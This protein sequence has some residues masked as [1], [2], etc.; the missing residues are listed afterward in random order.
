MESILLSEVTGESNRKYTKDDSFEQLLNSVKEYGIIEPPVVRRIA[1]GGFRLLAGRRRV[2]AAR[3]LKMARVD[4]VVREPDDPVDDEEIALTENVNRTDMH[5]LDEAAAFK[6]MADEGNA[7]EEIAR[8]YARSPSAIYQRLRLA[9][10]ITAL[11]ELFRDGALTIS[12]AVV[13]AELPEEDQRK[14]SEQY[15]SSDTID[16][17]V[18]SRFV[19]KVQ[20]FKIKTCM[21]EECRACG[22]RTHNTGN[23]LFEEFAH[24]RDVCLDGDCYRAKWYELINTA[25]AEQMREAG[26][27]TDNKIYFR[28]GFSNGIPELLYKKGDQVAFSAGQETPIRF[29]VLRDKDYVFS[30]ETKKKTGACWQIGEDLE[31]L[32]VTRIGYKRR[33]PEEGDGGNK[34]DDGTR[35]VA[36]YG[37]EEM[38]YAAAAR[39][40]TA[41]ELAR[42]LESK[43][44][45]YDFREKIEKRVYKRVIAER[46]REERPRDYLSLF[47]RYHEH[48]TANAFTNGSFIATEF[49]AGQQK[50]FSTLTG[51]QSLNELSL[52]DNTQKL[53]HFLL[54][55]FLESYEVP[56]LKEARDAAG[57][58]KGKGTDNVFL[59][60]AGLD[61]EG[62]QALYLD[63]A[64]EV[65]D[66]IVRPAP[67][68]S[69][70]RKR[71]ASPGN[72]E[73][74]AKVGGPESGEAYADEDED[75]FWP[76]E[77]ADDYPFQPDGDADGDEA[78]RDPDTAVD[79]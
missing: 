4:C 76:D 72:E 12:G 36:D 53:F 65:A 74:A 16:S 67:S 62:Y 1:G 31:G 18:I 78:L 40:M 28:S 26:L 5:P 47:L 38:E 13:L 70:G 64:R 2:E 48:E 66:N 14:F 33:T 11:K 35:L 34:T 22:K 32:F 20:R 75:L 54:L 30:G 8:Y 6:R 71:K 69:A 25:L 49:S 55:N 50:V 15:T 51:K 68:P 19:H 52:S 27:R 17:A 43:T 46:I 24:L 21:G 58:G 57:K 73:P 45:V 59:D 10:L 77:D 9:G 60:Y 42:E 23:E 79:P 44:T 56:T 41:V 37:Q 63:A 7:V 61:A 3:Q 39:G 29:E